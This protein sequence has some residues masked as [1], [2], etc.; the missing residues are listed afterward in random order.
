MKRSEMISILA[1]LH[2]A[3][4][5]PEVDHE[6]WFELVLNDIEDF[7]MLPPLSEKIA[8]S[9]PSCFLKEFIDADGYYTWDEEDD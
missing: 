8:K 7:G 4:L 2:G 6:A 1:S 9:T 5:G 3:V